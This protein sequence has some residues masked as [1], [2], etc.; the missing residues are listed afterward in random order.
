MMSLRI[1]G[2]IVFFAGAALLSAALLSDIYSGEYVGEVEVNFDQMIPVQN[3]VERYAISSPE[4]PGDEYSYHFSSP[5]QL[6]PE[7]SPLKIILASSFSHYGTP[8]KPRR[9]LGSRTY[10]STVYL[11]DQAGNFI[12]QHTDTIFNS[13]DKLTKASTGQAIG[14]SKKITSYNDISIAKPSEYQ[15]L[16]QLHEHAYRG[17]KPKQTY[18]FRAKPIA[19]KVFLTLLTFGGVLLVIGTIILA[20]TYKSA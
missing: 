4:G 16:I 5:I 17:L 19:S 9:K 18:T 15:I 2:A 12:W 3:I 7:N 1:F 6:D 13:L 11:V 8:F 10:P 14:S 20:R